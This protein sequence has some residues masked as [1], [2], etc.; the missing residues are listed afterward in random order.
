MTKL[1]LTRHG[2]TGANLENRFAGRSPEPLASEGV[3]QIESVGRL[4]VPQ[5]IAITAAGPLPRTLQSAQ[6]ISS[7]TGA[8]VV[9]K[10]GL[11]DISI[12]HWEGLTKTAI[13]ENFGPEYPLW[14]NHPESFSLPNCET[15]QNVQERAVKAVDELI[16]QFETKAILVVSHLIVLRCLELFFRRKPLDDFRS[17]AFDNG[18]VRRFSLEGTDM[19]RTVEIVDL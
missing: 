11:T 13:R 6:I 14:L 10:E 16:T 3:I 4:L 5:N 18:T 8:P 2:K 7:I 9:I 1:Y 15:L 19:G 12:P 17:I